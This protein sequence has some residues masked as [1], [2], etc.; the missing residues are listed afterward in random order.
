MDSKDNLA[1]LLDTSYPLLQT[2]RDAC[3]G[4]HKHSQA[5][6]SMI[7]RVATDLGLDV[8][9]MKVAAMYHDIGKMVFPKC[10]TEN[11]LE[12][13]NIHTDLPPEISYQIIT[14]HVSDSV[15]I[16]IND[17]R[18][19]REVIEI[20]SQH[21]GNSVCA[22]FFK[23]SDSKDPD[24]Y[25]Y[26]CSKPRSIQSAILMICDHIEAISKSDV[27][28]GKFDPAKLID[29]TINNLLN[30]GQLDE[31]TMKLGDLKVIKGAL[32]KELEGLYQKRVD[33]DKAEK[34]KKK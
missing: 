28:S 25:R 10:F 4:T 29:A 34:E 15:N 23:K 16:L 20:I 27:Q 11:Q 7:E 12:D 21:H 6:A 24:E 13:E 26:K 8:T 2:F 3:P 22:Y 17:E 9:F 32:A 5:V 33:Y 14:K 19:P 30:D 18:F 1:E 31:V